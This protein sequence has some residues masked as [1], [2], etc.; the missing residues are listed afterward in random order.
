MT[1]KQKTQAIMRYSSGLFICAAVLVM[2]MYAM[3]GE[4]ATKTLLASRQ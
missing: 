4:L 3:Y 1:E 2:C